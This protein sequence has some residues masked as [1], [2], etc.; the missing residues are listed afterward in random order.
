MQVICDAL[1]FG[2]NPQE[3]IEA[4]R[5]QHGPQVPEPGAAPADVLQME[6]RYTKEVQGELSRLGHKVQVIGP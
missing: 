3:A 2:M 5:W 6:E 4:P 1:D